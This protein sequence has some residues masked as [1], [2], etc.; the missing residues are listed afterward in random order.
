MN[1][2]K[3]TARLS[4]LGLLFL[5]Q[6][7]A[8]AQVDGAVLVKDIRPGAASSSPQSLMVLNGRVLFLAQGLAGMGMWNTDG[9]EE[10]TMYLSSTKSILD[11]FTRPDGVLLYSGLDGSI[12]T[13]LRRT[14]GTPPGTTLVKDIYP[15]S[16]D[17]NPS[18]FTRIGSNILFLVGSAT[19]WRTDGT[20]AGTVAVPVPVSVSSTRTTPTL[21][22]LSN[23]VF[24][25]TFDRKLWHTDGFSPGTNV[26]LPDIKLIEPN[27]VP[28]GVVSGRLLFRACDTNN[29]CELWSTD[30]TPGDTHVVKD[31]NPGSAHAF[32]DYPC[33][34]NDMLFFFAS[35][36]SH[37]LELWKSDGTTAGTVMVKDCRPGPGGSGPIS[38][39]VIFPYQG[40]VFF[41]A[42]D[43]VTRSLWRSDGTADGTGPLQAGGGTVLS[44]PADYRVL[45]GLL[46]FKAG[47][48]IWQSDGTGVG[49]RS[50]L[51]ADTGYSYTVLSNQLYFRGSAPGVGVELFKIGVQPTVV[52]K[53]VATDAAELTLELRAPAGQ[54]AALEASEDLSLW[55]PLHTNTVSAQGTWSWMEPLDGVKRF[56]RARWIGP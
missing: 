51:P 38:T 50:I 2:K 32:P 16:A 34:L 44:A 21:V 37:G 17:S 25:A 45:E 14:D 31:I 49:T 39:D 1:V 33:V 13:E 42:F 35:N 30:G 29:G 10:G 9:T 53:A 26:L 6:A 56:Y 28:L 54:R 20:E 8:W 48:N 4:S 47:T 41:G 43:G 46:Y 27:P 40:G 36:S 52:L 15:G 24:F 19:L 18:R 12:G 55:Q 3:W 7:A 22:P 5:A 11:H 23:E